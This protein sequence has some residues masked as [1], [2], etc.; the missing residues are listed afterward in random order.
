MNKLD[1]R[2]MLADLESARKQVKHWPDDGPGGGIPSPYTP[3]EQD[4]LLESSPFASSLKSFHNACMKTAFLPAED[5]IETVMEIA[6]KQ[7]AGKIPLHFVG[8][9]LLE[10][11]PQFTAIRYRLARAVQPMGKKL[12]PLAATISAVRLQ[13]KACGAAAAQHLSEAVIKAFQ[14][15]DKTTLARIKKLSSV[16]LGNHRN[17]QIWFAIDEIIKDRSHKR[18]KGE[19]S[20]VDFSMPTTAD[21][22]RYVTE[23]SGNEA[24]DD[25]PGPKDHKGWTRL[26]HDS[27]ADLVIPKGVRGKIG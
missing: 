20:S 4:A 2:K 8:L 26:W 11:Q 16:P 23:H 13:D 17:S 12:D 18:G 5:Q 14:K 21:I 19:K 15:D 25:L 22:R 24:F 10:L 6:R 1:L 9:Y 7:F 3:E 27:G